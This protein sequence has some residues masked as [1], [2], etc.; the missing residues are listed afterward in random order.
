[1]RLPRR[2]LVLKYGPNLPLFDERFI[3]YGYNKIEY[4]EQL[5]FYR[6]AWVWGE[7]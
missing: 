7:R 6:T 1:M 2:Y 4:M 3:N 5:R